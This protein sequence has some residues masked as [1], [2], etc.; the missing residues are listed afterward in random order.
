LSGKLPRANWSAAMLLALYRIRASSLIAI[1]Q[2]TTFL[3]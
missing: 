1:K 3:R 2:A